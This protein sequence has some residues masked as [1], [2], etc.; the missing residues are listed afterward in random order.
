MSLLVSSSTEDNARMLY[1]T[2]AYL[3]D[4]ANRLGVSIGQVVEW[5]CGWAYCP[6]CKRVNSGCA[7]DESF[8]HAFGTE[9]RRWYGCTECGHY[10]M[11]KYGDEVIE[12][13]ERDMQEEW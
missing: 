9:V 2:G 6:A 7:W 4:I 13:P 1:E 8:D 10:L 12:N 5:N 11:D 3:P